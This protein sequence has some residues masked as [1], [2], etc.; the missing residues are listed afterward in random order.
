MIFFPK[1]KINLGL[2]VVGKRDD[3]Y[4]NLSS[5][6]YPIPFGD[7]LEIVP[8][9][10]RGAI[11]LKESGI[12]FPGNPEDN[13]VVSAY[14]MMDREFD[15]PSVK[16]HLHKLVPAGAGLGGGSADAAYMIK[17]LNN[18]FKLNLSDDKMRELALS[19]G[20][21]CPFFIADKPAYVEG[22]GEVLQDIDLDLSDHFIVLV[23]PDI[24]LSTAEAFAQITPQPSPWRVEDINLDNKG[25]WSDLLVNDFESP[26]FS[27]HPLCADIKSELQKSGAYFVSM[28]GSGSTLYALYEKE[29]PVPE[30]LTKH[31]TWSGKL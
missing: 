17:G 14:R 21:D 13:L 11:E 24:H 3:G 22:R 2:S 5:I 15:L 26:V 18:M 25:R 6:F 1:T 20:S 23:K 29:T 31:F 9:E 19:H 28:S 10:G 8:V 16:V 30:S 12:P 7:V 4:H 27:R